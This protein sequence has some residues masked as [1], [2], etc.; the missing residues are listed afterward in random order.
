MCSSDLV[1]QTLKIVRTATP[2]QIN[3]I[4]EKVKPNNQIMIDKYKKMLLDG[5][6]K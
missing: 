5:V 3:M 2:E 1:D 4:L 6:N